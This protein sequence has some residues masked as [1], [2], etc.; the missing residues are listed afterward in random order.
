[1]SRQKTHFHRQRP[2]DVV[3]A[4]RQIARKRIVFTSRKRSGAPGTRR[5][6]AYYSGRKHDVRLLP[7]GMVQLRLDGVL[8]TIPPDWLSLLPAM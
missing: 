3:H 7:T 8:K 1:M 5:G 4:R 2:C 6:Y